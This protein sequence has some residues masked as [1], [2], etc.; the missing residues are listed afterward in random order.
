[1]KSTYNLLRKSIVTQTFR[2]FGGNPFSGVAAKEMGQDLADDFLPDREQLEI[3]DQA[4]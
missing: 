1:M 3:D 2:S 4:S